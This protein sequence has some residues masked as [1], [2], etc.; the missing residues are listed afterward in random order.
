MAWDCQRGSGRES[1]P[2]RPLSLSRPASRL[3]LAQATDA[4]VVA[5]DMMMQFLWSRCESR[6]AASVALSGSPSSCVMQT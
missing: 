2:D 1:R 3:A 5:A 6:P 4:V